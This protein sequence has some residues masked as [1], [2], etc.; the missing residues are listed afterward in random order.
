MYLRAQL[1]LSVVSVFR[2]E[3]TSQPHLRRVEAVSRCEVL[4]FFFGFFWHECGCHLNTTMNTCASRRL[5]GMVCG[6]VIQVLRVCYISQRG[7]HLL[8][9]PSYGGS[10]RGFGRGFRKAPVSRSTLA[11]RLPLSSVQR[12][13]W[14]LWWGMVAPLISQS[15]SHPSSK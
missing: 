6:R 1:Q 2:E 9:R 15:R 4:F 13:E 10:G 7:Q 14:K 3:P 5:Q 11:K 12:R 8:A